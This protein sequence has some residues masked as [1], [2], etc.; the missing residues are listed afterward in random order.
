[1]TP[2]EV[3]EADPDAAPS[4]HQSTFLPDPEPT[5]QATWKAAALAPLSYLA[6]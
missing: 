2:R 4:N 5:L 6:K 3:W 1:M